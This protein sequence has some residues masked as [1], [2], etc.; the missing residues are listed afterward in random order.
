MNLE[1]YIEECKILKTKR[2]P[3]NKI[4]YLVIGESPPISMNYF[5]KPMSLKMN[6]PRI[7]AQIFR[8]FYE[9]N[10]VDKFTYEKLL[11]DLQE[12]KRFYLDD[13]SEYPLDDYESKDR[14]EK[15]I[16]SLIEFH[17]RFKNFNLDYKCCKVLVLPKQTIEEFKNTKTINSWYKILKYI[18]LSKSEVCIFSI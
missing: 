14:V 4:K 12:N 5:Y 16:E 18:G 17:A 3:N 15:I 13:L 1:E 9:K 2:I 8:A 7:P 10:G 6:S 11:D